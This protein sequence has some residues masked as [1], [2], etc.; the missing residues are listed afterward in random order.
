MPRGNVNSAWDGMGQGESCAVSSWRG[1]RAVDKA[2]K[3]R[4]R[5]NGPSSKATGKFELFNFNEYK[6]NLLPNQFDY[7]QRLPS[8]SPRTNPLG[9]DLMCKEAVFPW[10]L[11]ETSNP[12]MARSASQPPKIKRPISQPRGV[13]PPPVKATPVKAM[14]VDPSKRQELLAKHDGEKKKDDKKDGDTKDA[15]KKTTD[16]KDAGKIN[17]KKD[18]VK[19]DGDKKDG[20]KKDDDKNSDASD[21][22]NENVQVNGLTHH[23]QHFRMKAYFAEKPV[24]GPGLWG[25]GQRW[26]KL[27][28]RVVPGVTMHTRKAAHCKEAVRAFRHFLKDRFGTLVLAWRVALDTENKGVIEWDDFGRVIRVMG[29]GQVSIPALWAE[30]D[31]DESGK[32]TLSEL[33]PEEAD[34]LGCFRGFLKSKYETPEDAWKAFDEDDPPCLTE[35]DFCS[36]CKDIGWNHSAA[37]VFKNLLSDLNGRKL[38]TLKDIEWLDAPKEFKP[39]KVRERRQQPEEEQDASKTKDGEGAPKPKAAPCTPRNIPVTVVDDFIKYLRVRYGNIIRAWRLAICP[40][41]P[42]NSCVSKIE[43]GR[44]VRELGYGGAIVQLWNELDVDGNGTVSLVEFA[45]EQLDALE[46]FR[47]QLRKTFASAQCVWKALSPRVG[48]VHLAM[49][50]FVVA[51]KTLEIKIRSKWVHNLLCSDPHGGH[52]ILVADIEFLGLPATRPGPSAAELRSHQQAF[53]VDLEAAYQFMRTPKE[54]RSE[55]FRRYGT[56]VQA[57]RNALSLEGKP[58]IFEKEFTERA[59]ELGYIGPCKTLWRSFADES[60]ELKLSM[61]APHIIDELSDFRDVLTEQ[62]KSK[63]GK[64]EASIVT[65]E[66]LLGMKED[67]KA[68]KDKSEDEKDSQVMSCEDFEEKCKDMGWKRDLG[69][70]SRIVSSF[71]DKVNGVRLVDI[72]WVFDYDGEA[73]AKKADEAKKGKAKEEKD[74]APAAGGAGAGGKGKGGGGGAPRGTMIAGGGGGGKGKKGG[75]GAAPRGTMMVSS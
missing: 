19:K 8:K 55:L 24:E 3:V 14:A 28:H 44:A 6:M 71:K 7:T 36:A 1:L 21:S 54:F 29:F 63:D 60:E 16:K 27:K 52:Y 46:E 32:V 56:L 18:G 48:F 62:L 75:G 37:G 61:L 20:D 49:D 45:P 23:G 33:C 35:Q 50:D 11:E 39:M 9:I 57:W 31:E 66:E 68:K 40:G 65:W 42:L 38:I 47:D 67:P 17:D 41:K 73:T 30:L 51:C 53:A 70:L 12:R 15:G 26:E 10:M 72:E 74:K 59:K 58:M 13:P 22:E 25:P 34:E 69:R 2:E 4:V 5:S 64:K 43:F